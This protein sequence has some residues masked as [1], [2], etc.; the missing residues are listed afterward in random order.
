VY[1]NGSQIPVDFPGFLLS[2]ERLRTLERTDGDGTFVNEPFEFA[3]LEPSIGEPLV[4][5]RPRGGE[6]LLEGA[7]YRLNLWCNESEYEYSREYLA[8]A[9]LPTP[10]MILDVREDPWPAGPSVY[11]EL[12]EEASI[13]EQYW[14]TEMFVDGES[15]GWPVRLESNMF[16]GVALQCPGSRGIDPG[17]HEVSFSSGP[18]D[19]PFVMEGPYTMDFQCDPVR[20]AEHEEGCFCTA[21]PSG[22]SQVPWV[23]AALLLIRRRR[24]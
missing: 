10:E 3:E 12:R 11:V 14:E 6:P 24:A 21:G 17:V 8:V 15:T 7:T 4:L 19:M 2:N 18:R 13:Y 20:V 16:F 5:V 23:L 22:V 1:P 9:P